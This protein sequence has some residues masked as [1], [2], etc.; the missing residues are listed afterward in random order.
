MGRPRIGITGPDRGGLA[1]WLFGAFS[2]FRAGGWP[3][4]IRPGRPYRGALDGLIIGGG[5]DVDPGL[6]AAEPAE[7]EV[8]VEE[9]GED[10]EQRFAAVV[11]GVIRRALSLSS[12]GLE[13]GGD[14]ARDALETEWLERAFAEDLPVL[15]ICRGMQLLNVVG[16]GDLIQDI[17]PMYTEHAYVRSV[18][19]RKRIEVK[20]DS[21][22]AR[23]LCRRECRVN[24]LHRQAVQRLGDGFAAVAHEASGVVQAIE[25]VEK[26]F[27]L[28]LQWHPELLP[29]VP[30][31]RRLFSGL[32][33]AARRRRF[34]QAGSLPAPPE[35]VLEEKPGREA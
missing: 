10:L 9:A 30:A 15:G 4:R 25:H 11:I 24:A 8:S 5:A 31:Q 1:G 17:R 20:A 7:D 27:V 21:L 29:Q 26:P 32:I 12:R 18:W 35:R 19:P 14:R 23:T 2:V 13:P 22:L 34:E 16:G 6:Y 3:V 33:R 28:G